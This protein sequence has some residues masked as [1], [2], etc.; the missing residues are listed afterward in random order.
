MYRPWIYA[1]WPW[2][3]T[4][5]YAFCSCILT[6]NVLQAPQVPDIR[7]EAWRCA[8]PCH[9]SVV[10]DKSKLSQKPWRVGKDGN[11]TN[12]M[13]FI[14]VLYLFIAHTPYSMF[15]IFSSCGS[16]H[17]FNRGTAGDKVVEGSSAQP[18]VRGRKLVIASGSPS[19]R[20]KVTWW[21]PAIPLA[22]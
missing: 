19:E 21:L 6:V 10:R 7:M 17:Q 3:P 2:R 14:I 22:F 5:A 18:E 20:P 13:F 9:W 1:Y 12:S 4:C 15:F 8:F 11:Y 16:C